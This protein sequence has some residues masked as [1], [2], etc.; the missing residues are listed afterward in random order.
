MRTLVVARCI[1]RFSKSAVKPEEDA[2]P[3]AD[4]YPTAF[5]A[6]YVGAVP[7]VAQAKPKECELKGCGANSM[8]GL[9]TASGRSL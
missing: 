6:V 8:N 1:T 2:T 9:G 3:S 5:N 4:A 7:A